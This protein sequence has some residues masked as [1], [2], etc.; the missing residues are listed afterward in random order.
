MP[1]PRWTG[2]CALGVVPV[3]N[4]NDSVATAEIRFGDNDRL[5]ARIAQAAGAQ[6]VLL[7]SDVDGL[8]DRQS[9][10]RSLG[11]PDP[12]GYAPRRPH[13]RRGRSGLGLR[14]GLGRHGMSKLEAA[15]IALSAGAHLAIASGRIE[16]PL[17]RFVETGHGTLFRAAGQEQARKAWLAGRLTARG[18]IAVDA[19]AVATLGQGK[20]LLPAGAVSRRG[21]I[22]LRGDVV[23]IAGPDGAVIAAASPNMTRRMPPASSGLRSAALA[24]VLGQPPRASPRPPRS[25]GDAVRTIALTGGTGF[26]GGNLL[27]LAVTCGF[28]VRALARGPQPARKA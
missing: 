11:D 14:H 24:Q 22:S 8:Y 20:S 7:L 16:H 6:G 26:V 25:P 1:P 17:A 12:R 9:A 23:D 19:G 5:A 27:A 3:V 18:C 21:P 13:P 4:E 2:C 10:A 15:R 28:E